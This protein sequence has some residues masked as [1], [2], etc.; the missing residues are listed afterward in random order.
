MRAKPVSLDLTPE[1]A[2]ERPRWRTIRRKLALNP[3][4]RPLEAPVGTAFASILAGQR[5]VCEAREVFF[6]LLDWP[7]RLP[8]GLAADDVSDEIGALRARHTRPAELPQVETSLG[9]LRAGLGNET[10]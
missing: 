6:Y 10:A 8:L 2:L 5:P 7:L 1:E 9:E 4:R 3:T